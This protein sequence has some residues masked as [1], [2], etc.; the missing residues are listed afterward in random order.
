MP[1]HEEPAAETGDRRVTTRSTNA[2]KHPG[3]EAVNALRVKVRREPQVV[4]AEK[5]KKQAAKEMKEKVH[6]AEVSKREAAQRDLENFQAE[7]ASNLKVDAAPRQQTKR[8]SLLFWYWYP[9][10]HIRS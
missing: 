9:I 8:I 7:Q 3:T 1:T 6:R 5:E 10:S 4:Q 2:N